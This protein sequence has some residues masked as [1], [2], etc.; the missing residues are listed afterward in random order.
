MKVFICWSGEL[1]HKVAIVLKDWLPSV[2]QSLE[3]YV[4][5]EDI[6]KGTRWST[7]LSKELEASTFGI[8]CVTRENI[9][10]PWLNF[11]AGALSKSVEQSRVAPFLFRLKRSE[12]QGPLLQFQSTIAERED[13][14]K[15]V[16]S[17]NGVEETKF[18]EA[19][20]LDLIFDVWWPK[21]EDSLNALEGD[22]GTEEKSDVQEHSPDLSSRTAD[23]LEEVLELVRRQQKILNSP[24]ELLPA[25]YLVHIFRRANRRFLGHRI[26]VDLRETW[27]E[28]Q[29][30]VR[31]FDDE[32]SVPTQVVRDYLERLRRP[33]EHIIHD[34][35][36]QRSFTITRPD[37]ES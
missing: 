19:A 1:S 11:E 21:L 25:D 23:I 31:S 24:A 4:S 18:I 27:H 15:L 16:H 6:D 32:S 33:I 13:V 3:P 2:I 9:T 35:G 29:S 36:L 7:D 30:V 26:F 14:L 12:V 20:R 5:S 22:I 37:D 34:A 28:F 17:L 8:L 10:A